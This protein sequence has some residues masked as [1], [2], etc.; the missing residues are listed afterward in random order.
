MIKKT[1]NY[2]WS[3]RREFTKYFIVGFSGL[4][5]DMGSLILFKEIF[6]I[7]PV[8]VVIVSQAFLLVYNFTKLYSE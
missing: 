2:F 8:M 1:V 4:F 6:G 5:L 7:D 3:L